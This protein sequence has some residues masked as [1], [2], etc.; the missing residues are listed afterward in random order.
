[1]L[2]TGMVTMNTDFQPLQTLYGDSQQ[3]QSMN[4]VSEP[5]QPM[6]TDSQPVQTLNTESVMNHDFQPQMITGECR[7]RITNLCCKVSGYQ[8]AVIEFELCHSLT[9][10]CMT[11]STICVYV[12]CSPLRQCVLSE[13]VSIL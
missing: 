9:Q 11:L 1:M 12:C 5:L 7:H 3:L 13:V 2:A 4:T 10:V 6:N 8:C